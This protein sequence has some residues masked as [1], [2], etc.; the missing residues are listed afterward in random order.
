MSV[1]ALLTAHR[2]LLCMPAPAWPKLNAWAKG[3]D[4]SLLAAIASLCADLPSVVSLTTLY[5][6]ALPLLLLLL[7]L[8]VILFHLCAVLRHH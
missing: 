4:S 1:N 8:P 5:A 3:I 6:R 7:L 2:Q